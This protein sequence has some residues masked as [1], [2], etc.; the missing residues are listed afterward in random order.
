MWRMTVRVT[1]RVIVLVAV[2]VVVI[3]NVGVR[4]ELSQSG[5]L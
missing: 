2:G 5:M 4:H 1:M 3:M